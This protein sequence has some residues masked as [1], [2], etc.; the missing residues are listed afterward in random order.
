MIPSETNDTELYLGTVGCGN[1]KTVY[2]ALVN[3]NPVSIQLQDVSVNMTGAQVRVV[4]VKKGN[5]T[6]ETLSRVLEKF[7][8]SLKVCI[9][10][11][12]HSSFFLSLFPFNRVPLFLKSSEIEFIF[13]FLFIYLF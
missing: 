4:A 7:N 10:E 8:A 9:Y 1:V 3:E 11:T 6:L 2:F 5:V 13:L 12:N